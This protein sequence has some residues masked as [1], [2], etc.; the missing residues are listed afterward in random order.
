M[1]SANSHPPRLIIADDNIR[2]VGGHYFELATLLLEGAQTLGYQGV[3]ATHA[4]FDQTKAVASDIHLL[5]TFH[6]RR[7]VHWSLGVDGHSRFRRNLQGQSVGGSG[8]EN[9]CANLIDRLRPKRCPQQMLLRWA[10]DLSSLLGQLRPGP[11]DVLL[12][13]T[14][15]DFAMLALAAAIKQIPLAPLR[16]DVLFHFALHEASEPNHSHRLREIGRQ[17]RDALKHLQPH[18][19]RLHAT[20]E[21]LAAQLRQTECGSRISAVPYPTRP[22][23]ISAS[24]RS[25]QPF[26]AVLAGLPRAEKGRAAIIDLL[27]AI[28]DTLL[29][30]RRFRVSMQMPSQ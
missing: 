24:G 7:L 29:K 30:H 11:Q 3:L 22:R 2:N 20:T 15:D 18:R 23:Q 27:S 14:G 6:T 8:I 10:D 13:N 1:N 25:N 9:F 21:N 12:I 4:C 5:P 26:K 19:L 16:I 28:E 17:I